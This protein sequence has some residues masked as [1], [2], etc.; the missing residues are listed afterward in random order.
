MPDGLASFQ[1]TKHLITV[2]WGG[3]SVVADDS[4]FDEVA[5]LVRDQRHGGAREMLAVALGNMRDP[6]AVDLLIEL[7]ADEEVAGHALIAIGKLKARK[8]R[9]H[10]E[11]F[12][13]DDKAWVR[14]E[15]RR[16]LAK[17]DKDT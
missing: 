14:G 10:V 6:R 12:L 11:R 9:P 1:A 7:L 16:A 3:T 15:A 13:N 17:I 5:E 2:E 8:A 4:I